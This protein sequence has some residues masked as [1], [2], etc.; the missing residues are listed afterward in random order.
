LDWLVLGPQYL[1]DLKH[2]EGKSLSFFRV[3]SDVSQIDW[4]FKKILL[5][6]PKAFRLHHSVGELY[7]D[8]KM[9]DVIKK[10]MNNQLRMSRYLY[11]PLIP[12][13]KKANEELV[14]LF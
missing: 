13:M 8:E 7:H 4:S 1:L 9:A 14:K 2:C 6:N 10:G 11:R 3:I 12:V 5:I